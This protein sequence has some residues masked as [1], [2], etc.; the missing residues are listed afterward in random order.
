M[1]YKAIFIH[2]QQSFPRHPNGTRGPILCSSPLNRST[3]RNLLTSIVLISQLPGLLSFIRLLPK[4]SYSFTLKIVPY[5][6]KV[7]LLISAPMY[8][9]CT[10]ADVSRLTGLC[11][12]H[13]LANKILTKSNYGEMSSAASDLIMGKHCSSWFLK[14]SLSQLFSGI[15]L[16]LEISLARH[17][18][19]ILLGY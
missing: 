19:A 6:P 16:A 9:N 15:F 17:R 5:S 13:R 11:N 2:F 18:I 3:R 8:C 4:C 7:I 14:I 12:M 10:T 1:T